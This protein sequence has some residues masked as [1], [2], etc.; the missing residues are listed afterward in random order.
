VI[1]R[2]RKKTS[3]IVVLQDNSQLHTDGNFKE[4]EKQADNFFK[5]SFN[6]ITKLGN[7]EGRDQKFS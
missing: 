3:K 2:R 4:K 7:S 1:K 6:T 5:L